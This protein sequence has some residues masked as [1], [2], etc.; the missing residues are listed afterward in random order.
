[1]KQYEPV[2]QGPIKPVQGPD[3]NSRQQGGTLQPANPGPAIVAGTP[4]QVQAQSPGTGTST[5]ATT[6]STV[7]STIPAGPGTGAG[8]GV[9]PPG[10]GPLGGPGQGGGG[11]GGPPNQGLAGG[12]GT[13]VGTGGLPIQGQNEIPPDPSARY[14]G[15]Y[16]RWWLLSAYCCYIFFGG[17][18]LLRPVLCLG[19]LSTSIACQFSTWTDWQR[20]M[21]VVAFIWVLFLIG[22]LISHILGVR[23]IELSQGERT[24][25]GSA[26]RT[27]S[28]FKIIYPPLYIYG[29]VAFV[30]I[31]VAWMTN[32]VQSVFFA[33]ASITVFVVNSC[34]LYTR[35]EEDRRMYMLGYVV[36]AIGGIVA[37]MLIGPL[38]IIIFVSM[39]V[40]IVVSLLV[41]FWTRPPKSSGNVQPPSLTAQN[42]ATVTVNSIIRSL[43][44]AMRRSNATAASNQQQQTN[45]TQGP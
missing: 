26:V 12:P 35:Q 41:F 22:W 6:S 30:A 14:R 34:Y 45:P 9:V 25:V 8:A 40:V 36:L 5:Y 31:V 42:A 3:S 13:G 33:L 4:G 15:W 27:I 17:A 10:S 38:Q 1:M 16:P 2:E 11:A 19:S 29:I 32:H 7:S 20:Q 18:M 24:A 39:V 43:V 23:Y 28:E 44:R 21:I 37:L